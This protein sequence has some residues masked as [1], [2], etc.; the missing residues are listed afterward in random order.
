MINNIV[1][2]HDFCLYNDYDKNNYTAV[3]LPESYFNRFFYSDFESVSLI[4]RNKTLDEFNIN[5]LGFEKIKNK[6]IYIPIKIPS[7]INLLKISVF[8]R[9]IKE[10]RKCKLLVINYPSVIGTYVFLLNCIL[11]KKYVVEV[12][13]DADQFSQKKL[14]FIFSFIIRKIFPSIVKKSVGAIYVSKY[15]ENKYKSPNS[16][17]A[18]NVFVENIVNR[19]V[20]DNRLIDKDIVN[21]TFI[22]GIN[23]RKGISV[24][25]EAIN[26]LVNKGVNNL[27]VK[28]IGGHADS[29][30]NEL[31]EQFKLNKVIKLEGILNRKAVIDVLSKTDIYIQP[32]LTEGIP[33]ATIEALSFGIPVVATKLPG[34][35]E[36]LNDDVLI[37][38]SNS[39]QLADK[40]FQLLND[41]EFYNNEVVR[42]LTMAGNYLNV[43]LHKRRCDFYSH[44]RVS[45]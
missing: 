14:G 5:E 39:E 8:F 15:L 27:S 24:I 44:L 1:Y 22:G 12:A 21:I 4:S 26:I 35:Y 36:I 20:S 42:N 28:L 37:D 30:Y 9:I 45:I 41:I 6:E 29:N 13:A 43:N 17:V 25:V 3:G 34:F 31:I 19:E 32:S 18:S 16:I 38:V 7:Y 23:K 33:R 40:I 10:I 2:V 11:R